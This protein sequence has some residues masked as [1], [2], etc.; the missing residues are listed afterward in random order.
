LV[1]DHLATNA[2]RL[3]P[4]KKDLAAVTPWGEDEPIEFKR[5]ES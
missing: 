5:D 2:W 1:K 4:D 3:D